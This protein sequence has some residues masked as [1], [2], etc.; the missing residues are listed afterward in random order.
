MDGIEVG[1]CVLGGRS[2]SPTWALVRNKTG[3]TRLGFAVLLKFFEAERRSRATGV[4]SRL[5]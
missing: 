1:S 3:S 5:R 4:M 2:M